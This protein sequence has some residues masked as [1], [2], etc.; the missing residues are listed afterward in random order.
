M[1]LK[2]KTVVVTGAQGG[3]GRCLVKLLEQRDAK[4]IAVGRNSEANI[5]LADLADN[6]S[7]ES[8]CNKLKQQD[9]DILI[10]LAG[11]MHFGSIKQQPV[12]EL[13]KLIAVNLTTPI[14]LVQSVLPA[15][16]KKNKGMIVNIGSI[17]GSLPFPYFSAYSST[18]AGLKGFSDSLRREYQ[19]TGIRVTHISPRAVDTAFNTRAIDRFN[20]RTQASID[21]PE[22]VANII[23]N[24]ILTEK[25][26]VNVG[27]AENIFVQ[28]NKVVPS[29]VDKALN[30]KRYIASQIL[31][32]DHI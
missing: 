13:E 24:A 19:H 26:N 14:K 32:G 4:V 3:I 23:L 8:L 9:V 12:A 1:Q 10:N 17:F 5:T 30:S 29:I 22:K 6:D 27:F 11:L 21:T 25:K 31:A 18:K 2:N 7:V 16:E 15:M 20:E 28:I